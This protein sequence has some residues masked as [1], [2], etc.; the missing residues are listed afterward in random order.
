MLSEGQKK[1]KETFIVI[2]WI[3]RYYCILIHNDN[4]SSSLTKRSCT[5]VF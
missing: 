3:I 4:M 2:V 1:T 5:C